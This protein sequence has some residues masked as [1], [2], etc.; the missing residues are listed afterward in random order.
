MGRPRFVGR[1]W[2]TCVSCRGFRFAAAFALV[3]GSVPEIHAQ[4]GARER[5][6][7]VSAVYSG[8]EPVIGL[9]LGD[10]VIT[11]DG[12]RREVL[13]VSR[14]VEPMDIAL[15]VDNSAAA[16]RVI[17]RGWVDASSVE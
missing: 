16:G 15:L 13:R 5:T 11:E 14:A 6:L 12:R 2:A 9:D 7:F 17:G 10:F 1:G 8:G 3:V 4:A